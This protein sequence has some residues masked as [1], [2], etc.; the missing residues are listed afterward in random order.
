MLSA[1]PDTT[2]LN[3]GFEDIDFSVLEALQAYEDTKTQM[4]AELEAQV[5]EIRSIYTHMLRLSEGQA[6]LREHVA[7]RITREVLMYL[8]SV[9]RGWANKPLQKGLRQAWHHPGHQ[10][11]NKGGNI[12]T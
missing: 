11:R 2:V 5:E 10:Q 9:K 3:R 6:T 1:T 12:Q 7:L 4:L 8:S